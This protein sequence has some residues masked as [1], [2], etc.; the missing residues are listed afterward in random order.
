MIVKQI[1]SRKFWI[2]KCKWQAGKFSLLRFY[3]FI[4]L[5]FI[6]THTKMA[7]VLGQQKGMS[8]FPECAA[9]RSPNSRHFL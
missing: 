1:L 8:S 5:K 9:I 7:F 6:E 3:T 4:R 2:L